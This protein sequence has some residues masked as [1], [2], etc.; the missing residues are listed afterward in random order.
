MGGIVNWY[1][2][3]IKIFPVFAPKPVDFLKIP[4]TNYDGSWIK[5]CAVNIILLSFLP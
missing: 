3:R 4:T 1:F 5:V 2:T